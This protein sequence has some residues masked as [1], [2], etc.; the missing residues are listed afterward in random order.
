MSIDTRITD[1]DT[2]RPALETIGE[3][4]T[5]PDHLVE[6]R[7]RPGIVAGLGAGASLVVVA[8]LAR[9]ADGGSVVDW[10]VAAVLAVVGVVNLAAL[11]DARTPLL[12]ADD[13]GVRLRLG[14]TWVG[15]P[16]GGLHQVEHRARRGWWHDGLLVVHTHYVQRFLE[17]LDAPARRTARLNARL[18]RA[19]LA[20]PLGLG[21]K[22][23][24]A[25]EG[26]TA[27]LRDLSAGSSVR[28]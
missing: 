28:A 1:T 9:A 13:L 22:V 3:P 14:R 18:H 26:V 21:T 11:L 23:V 8:Y 27:A 5:T 2:D 4:T 17:D 15:L 20:V 16:W 10:V 19:P 12:V 7:R 25:P 6:V 24:G